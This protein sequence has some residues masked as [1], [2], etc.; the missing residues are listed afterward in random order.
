VQELKIQ[1]PTLFQYQT[2]SKYIWTDIN[3][4]ELLHT[5]KFIWYQKTKR[6]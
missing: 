4:N 2:A 6:V 1:T 3:D 5:L